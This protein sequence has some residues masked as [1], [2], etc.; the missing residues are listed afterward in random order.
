MEIE[1][2]IR[3]SN[4]LTVNGGLTVLDARYSEDCAGTQTS[5]TVLSLC[6]ND[7]TNAPKIVGVMG[8]RYEADL[9][10][11]WDFFISGQVRLESDQRTSTQAI[12][13]P[14]PAEIAAAGGNVQLAIDQAPLI[15][16]DIQDGSIFINARAGFGRIDD[17]LQLEFFVNN[18][19]D[20][21]VRGVTFNTPLRGTGASNSR[22]AFSLQPRT[23]GVTVRTRF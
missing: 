5:V 9:S 8:A 19:T 14:G 21:V 4:N 6:G 22:S 16:G 7:L 1:T 3:P 17:A 2:L 12:V 23:Y 18:L 13:P 15:V 20:S 10:N 11:D